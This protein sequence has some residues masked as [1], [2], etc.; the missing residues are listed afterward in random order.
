V[1]VLETFATGLVADELL[2]GYPSLIQERVKA[3]IAYVA[4]YGYERIALIMYP[5]SLLELEIRYM[6]NAI[7]QSH[8]QLTAGI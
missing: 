4:E 5:P 3:A 8:N 2:H 1:V 7:N 6:L